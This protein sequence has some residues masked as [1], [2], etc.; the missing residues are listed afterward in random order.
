VADLV[1]THIK[2]LQK[3]RATLEEAGATD[4][5]VVFTQSWMMMIP[6]RHAGRDGVCANAA[7]MVGMVWVKHQEERDAWTKEGLT[8]FLAFLGIPAV[9]G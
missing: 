8:E 1:Q 5:N 2:L 3:T 4:Y 9:S 7:G 6:R